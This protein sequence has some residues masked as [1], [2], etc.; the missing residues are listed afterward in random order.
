MDRPI[1]DNVSQELQEYEK[2]VTHLPQFLQLICKLFSEEFK[3]QYA[4]IRETANRKFRR[5]MT[6][7]LTQYREDLVDTSLTPT[8]EVCSKPAIVV[9]QLF[10][11][12]QRIKANI[13]QAEKP[14]KEA[15]EQEE[16]EDDPNAFDK[17]LE[18]ISYDDF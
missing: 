4:E 13:E 6:S 15:Q 5:Y 10:I 14:I 18:N 1:D 11:Q 3:T 16:D 7:N 9:Q 12:Y 17:T 8:Y 2:I